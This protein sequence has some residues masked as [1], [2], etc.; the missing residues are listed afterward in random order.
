MGRPIWPKNY[1]KT[2]S[3]NFGQRAGRKIWQGRGQ[4]IESSSPFTNSFSSKVSVNK[5]GQ[6]DYE[7]IDSLSFPIDSSIV[8]DLEVRYPAKDYNDFGYF[9]GFPF[10]LSESNEYIKIP[11]N[12]VTE[13]GTTINLTNGL[14]SRGLTGIPVSNHESL[15]VLGGGYSLIENKGYF[16]PLDND[17]SKRAVSCNNF[18]NL[19]AVETE[20]VIQTRSIPSQYE[21]GYAKNAEFESTNG[22]QHISEDYEVVDSYSD[23]PYLPHLRQYIEVTGSLDEVDGVNA[24]T[25]DP[26]SRLFQGSGQNYSSMFFHGQNTGKSVD[27]FLPLNI[28]PSN[29]GAF[30]ITFDEGVANHLESQSNFGPKKEFNCNM[31]LDYN[32]K[33]RD[34]EGFVG[35]N[36]EYHCFP[37]KAYIVPA[38]DWDFTVL[39]SKVKGV[40]YTYAQNKD[41]RFP[42]D[43]SS[44][45]DYRPWYKDITF[46]Y[47]KYGPARLGDNELNY[48]D[49]GYTHI[50]FEYVAGGSNDTTYG[51]SF[52]CDSRFS[53]LTPTIDT[54]IDAQY[55]PEFTSAGNY[56]LI[57]SGKPDLEFY[58][59]GNRARS[60]LSNAMIEKFYNERY[61]VTQV[62][63]EGT[64]I[65]TS[66]QIAGLYR[67]SRTYDYL[68]NDNSRKLKS[69]AKALIDTPIATRFIGRK[70]RDYTQYQGGAFSK[71][72]K[73]PSEVTEF[74][75][76]V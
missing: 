63:Q 32:I 1:S 20:F 14:S 24:C 64:S 15:S 10:L 7:N 5:Y 49:A 59:G 13:N 58:C 2:D 75:N 39:A 56:S 34:H 31:M 65:L 60:V 62:R 19:A 4:I 71:V 23:K 45:I 40:Y 52:S 53:Y 17:T 73:L 66:K 21:T 29:T 30:T 22:L 50:P 12:F 9:N 11:E 68:D 67:T 55:R 8:Q 44:L 70:V 74:P 25:I 18:W 61:K 72:D 76:R 51:Y 57:G 37:Y 41:L 6:K 46:T 54:S 48:N 35:S 69:K 26:E 3:N 42:G 27:F 43:Q 38:K 28:Q 16:N 47:S 36:I 33:D